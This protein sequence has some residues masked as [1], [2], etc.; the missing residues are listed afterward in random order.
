LPEKRNLG[1]S[2]MGVHDAEAMH[3]AVVDANRSRGDLYVQMLRT[4]ERRYGR[5]EAIAT[6]KDAIHAWGCGLAAG[7]AGLAAD[8][9]EGLKHRFALAPDG[10]AMFGARVDRCDAG[11][12]DVQ[13]ETCPL[14]AAWCEA[15]LPDDEVAQLCDIAAQADYG[16]LETAGFAVA[17]ETWRPGRS[18]CCVLCIRPRNRIQD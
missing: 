13:F 3:K 17:I 12:L 10:G 7:L 15:G 5:A 6:M 8:D 1:G 14:K 18:G 16:T 11:G 4:L 9:F 2:A